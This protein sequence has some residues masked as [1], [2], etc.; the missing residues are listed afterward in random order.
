MS[1][2]LHHLKA[3]PGPGGLLPRRLT[4]LLAGG[5]APLCGPPHGLPQC[6]PVAA[7]SPKACDCQERRSKKETAVSFMTQPRKSHP[8]ASVLSPRSHRSGPF[9]VEGDHTRAWPPGGEDQ[10]GPG[11]GRSWRPPAKCRNLSA[12]LSPSH[13]SESSGAPNKKL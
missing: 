4:W 10:W 3:Q 9:G 12:S 2:G 8:F 5:H 11:H 7:A 1:A 6:P 13:L